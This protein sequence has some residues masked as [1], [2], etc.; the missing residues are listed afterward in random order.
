MPGFYLQWIAGF[1]ICAALS[2]RAQTTL[3]GNIQMMGIKGT[4]TLTQ[5]SQGQP[6]TVTTALTGLSQSYTMELRELRTLYD[7]SSN[8][9][10]ASRLGAK[11]GSLSV[12]VT[13]TGTSSNTITDVT[14]IRSITGRSVVLTDTT[15]SSASVCA[16]LEPAGSHVTAIAQLP[17]TIAGTVTFR[18][19]SNQANAAASVCVDLFRVTD[20]GNTTEQTLSWDVYSTSVLADTTSTA[21]SQR[22]EN[23][24]TVDIDLTTK[25]GK[26]NAGL[27]KGQNVK[28]FVDTSLDVTSLFGKTLA[29]K[30]S[31]GT[32]LSCATIR[33][34]MKRTT[35]TRISRDGVKGTIKLTQESMYDPTVI[36]VNVTG[37]QSLAGGYH[38]HEWPVPQK[39]LKTETVCD[40]SHVAGH[41]NPNNVVASGSPSAGTGTVDQY[42]IGDISGKFGT[43]NGKSELME[44][45]TDYNLPLFG[46]NSV[47]GRS[48][49]IHKAAG[50]A[51]WVCAN[52]E[53]TDE[54]RI[55]QITFTYPYIGY[56]VFQQPILNWF[57]AET[58]I[59]VELDMNSQT[60]AS[61]DHKWHIHE[62]M[63]GMDSMATTDRCMSTGGHYNP[64][65]VDLEGNYASDCHPSNPHRCEVGDVA[66]KH[67]NINIGT[68]SEGKQRYFF[69]DVD[70]PLSGPLSIIGKSVVI[71]G[72]NSGG[73]RMSCANIYE[74]PKRAVKVDTWSQM[75][76]SSVSGYVKLTENSAGSL[77]GETTAE[78]N[79][80]NLA[81]QAGGLHVH[82]YP[83]PSGSGSPCSPGSVGGHF[84]PF[85][86]DVNTSPAN[87]TG[88]D[89]Q[90]EVGDLSGRYGNPL[91]GQ[92]SVG[93]TEM[94]SN[95]P[96]R[97]PLSVVGRS[98][99]IH[100]ADSSRW[101]CGNIVEDTAITK[102]VMYKAKAT[103]SNGT[104]Q[105][106]ITLM[107]Y[108]YPDGGMSDTDVIVD[109]FYA[110]NQS[111]T[112]NDHNW[113]VHEN[114]VTS[115]CMSTGGH[116][117]P[118]QVN[119]EQNYDECGFANPLRCELGDQAKKLG[120]YDVGKGRRF[121]TDV[122]LPLMGQF[123]VIGR[124]FVLHAEN[125]GGARVACADIMPMD[126]MTM[127]M[128]FPVMSNFNKET[129]RTQI[130]SALGTQPYNL[131]VEQVSSGTAASEGCMQAT[132]FFI[133]SE[134][135][136]LYNKLDSMM[137][138]SPDTLG[139]YAPTCAGCSNTCNYLVLVLGVVICLQQ[140]LSTWR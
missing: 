87:G 44:T 66:K 9:C 122:Y 50:G 7:G 98:I 136:T 94:D 101:L 10:S 16:T 83:V 45:Y 139:A 61:P 2:T 89:D 127:Q 60:G 38:I 121:Y 33:Q 131:M 129:M 133:G 134:S 93:V 15:N 120:K 48:F 81:S 40:G 113:H 67:G 88:S 71:H 100:K 51:R 132:V 3:I 17:S 62:K 114:Q 25:H 125:A 68:S 12:V 124:S 74:L 54:M 126:G 63:V 107:Q 31:D 111:Q 140:Y 21:L 108:A 24:G 34:V 112:S 72:A 84:N 79:L 82:V 13:N 117:N 135:N 55:A 18:Q 91:N 130:A 35:M 26:L 70:L 75:E 20:T 22:C 116:Y 27:Q 115:D 73:A 85:D 137:K 105:G 43:L 52:I 78:I 8:M 123:G 56:I 29:I 118:F 46:V 102:G 119:V 97:G 1:L 96:L 104:I 11:F 36:D 77:S 80:N 95:L 53:S 28:C 64:Y 90:Y 65:M 59:Y 57:N 32:I 42:E 86:V 92:T 128:T 106:T 19:A 5:T 47:I 37:L 58:Q 30:S 138:Q 49:V 76:S 41:F 4:V 39:L 103:F 69:T 109:L 6:I 110:Q 99:V 14:D 23:I